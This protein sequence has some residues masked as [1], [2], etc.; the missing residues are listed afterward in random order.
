[1]FHRSQ[2]DSCEEGR[3]ASGVT[4]YSCRWSLGY[5]T[6]TALAQAELM[7]YYQQYTTPYLVPQQVNN[8]NVQSVNSRTSHFSCQSRGD[9]CKEIIT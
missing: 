7:H 1:M 2:E 4:R 6:C 9:R 8:C 5:N 3:G